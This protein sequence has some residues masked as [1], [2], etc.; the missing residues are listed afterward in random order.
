MKCT[1]KILLILLSASVFLAGCGSN[2]LGLPY[3]AD[4]NISSFRMVNF[5]STK[6][7]ADSFAHDLCVADSDVNVSALDI[8]VGTAAALFDVNSKNT[9]YAKNINE[10]FYPASLTKVM[11]A[12]VALKY[13]QSDM[14][15]TASTNSTDISYDA[16]AVKIKAGDTMTLDQALHLLLIYSAND[17]ANLIAEGVGGSMENF[18]N[19]MN[20]EAL[21]IGATNTH[22]SNPHGLSD[23]NHY[24]T[25]YDLYLIMN[26]ATKFELFNEIIHTAEYE[27]VYY[28]AAGNEKKFSCQSTNL[29]LQ[30]TRS[31]PSGITVI[32]GKT[33]TTNAAGHCLVLLSKDIRSNPYI[34]IVMKAESREELYD[35][36]TSLLGLIGN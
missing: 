30:G 36:M 4:S 6:S 14:I 19:M 12:I 21:N 32:G 2:K 1:N 3:T 5:E 27:T 18:V 22:F 17:V 29:F 10:K 13:G 8:D 33:G 24:T 15:L 11:T 31:A 20:E 26:E 34:S 23:D 35:Y 28:D 9:I 16:Q 7:T 25:P